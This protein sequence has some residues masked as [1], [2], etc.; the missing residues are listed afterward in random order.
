[1][2]PSSISV[3]NKPSSANRE[4]SNAAIQRTPVPADRR[5]ATS[6]D[7]ANGNS[8]E[9]MTKKINGVAS[10]LQRRMASFK[11]RANMLVN[12]PIARDPPR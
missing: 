11:S 1:M 10:S 3:R 6:G 8:E 9:M 12:T 2:L 4:D 7:K 5:A